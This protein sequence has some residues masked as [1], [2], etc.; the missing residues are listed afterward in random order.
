MGASL[1]AIESNSA[2]FVRGDL[3]L[4]ARSEADRIAETDRSVC[5]TVIEIN[6]DALLLNAI[7]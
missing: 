3:S 7:N 4:T 1:T 6:P 5:S 2:G